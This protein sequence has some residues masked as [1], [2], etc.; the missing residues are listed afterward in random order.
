MMLPS[1]KTCPLVVNERAT[2]ELAVRWPFRF[3]GP[4]K[5]SADFFLMSARLRPP[6]PRRSL[7][8]YE[9]KKSREIKLSRHH[10][11]ELISFTAQQISSYCYNAMLTDIPAFVN[12][13]PDEYA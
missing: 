11:L 8:S 6:F 2:L 13:G 9:Q 3:A 7:N 10:V 1:E 12:P 4:P 5:L